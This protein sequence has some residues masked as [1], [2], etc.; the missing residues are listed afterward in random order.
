MMPF[1]PFLGHLI[2]QMLM[3]ISRRSTPPESPRGTVGALQA[4]D[5]VP[6][7]FQGGWCVMR[8]EVLIRAEDGHHTRGRQRLVRLTK[9]LQQRIFLQRTECGLKR[10]PV[11]AFSR[12]RCTVLYLWT[13]QRCGKYTRQQRVHHRATSGAT[14]RLALLRSR[15]V[16]PGFWG[17]CPDAPGLRPS[18]PVCGPV[19]TAQQ[20]IYQY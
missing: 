10:F 18:P 19:V 3:V 20:Q 11:H 5:A 4:V 17:T 15:M 6:C 2:T 1:L 16:F 8:R 14:L 12:H 13:T 7:A 9:H